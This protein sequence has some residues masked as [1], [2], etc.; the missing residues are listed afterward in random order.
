MPWMKKTT[1]RLT[2]QL[3]SSLGRV[4]RQRGMSQSELIRESIRRELEADRVP[5]RGGLFAGAR[6]AALDAD[7]NL[8]GFGE[9]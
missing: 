3:K 7:T 6:P 9:R 5:A 1:V 8:R 2:P 4:A